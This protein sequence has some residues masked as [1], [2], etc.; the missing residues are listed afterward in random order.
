[1]SK[2]SVSIYIIDQIMYF[3]PN[4]NFKGMQVMMENTLSCSTNENSSKMAQ[5]L[6]DSFDYCKSVDEKPSS[7]NFKDFIKLTKSKSHIG[8]IRRAKFVMASN[9]DGNLNL[10]RVEPNFKYKA[11]C[12]ES[13]IP[14]ETYNIIDN[15]LNRLGDKL[16]I[17][18]SLK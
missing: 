9:N 3:K 1:M 18:S 4:A 2:I 5:T 16:K 13:K 17:V 15:D 8:L 7:N 6:I 10:L 14:P 11:F 12:V